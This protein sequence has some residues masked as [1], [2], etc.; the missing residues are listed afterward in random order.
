MIQ[1]QYFKVMYIKKLVTSP[2]TGPTI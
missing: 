1:H 2:L